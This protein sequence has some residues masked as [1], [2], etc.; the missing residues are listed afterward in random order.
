[1][2][3]QAYVNDIHVARNQ[4]EVDIATALYEQRKRSIS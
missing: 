1:M 4:E 2:Y 3:F